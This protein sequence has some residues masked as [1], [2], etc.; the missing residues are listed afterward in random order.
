MDSPLLLKNLLWFQL[1]PFGMAQDDL[2]RSNVK[3]LRLPILNSFNYLFQ[4]INTANIDKVEIEMAWNGPSRKIEMAWNGL[5]WKLG[6]AWN[7]NLKWLELVSAP[8]IVGATQISFW[9]SLD[10]FLRILVWPLTLLF[11]SFAAFAYFGPTF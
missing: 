9:S 2:L 3:E 8:L 10:F 5:K 7:G 6:M 1:Q 4:G 11:R